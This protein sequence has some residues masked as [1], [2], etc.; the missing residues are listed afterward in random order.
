MPQPIPPS[1]GSG[2]E[3][4]ASVRPTAATG[5]ERTRSPLDPASPQDKLRRKNIR[6]CPM[7]AEDGAELEFSGEVMT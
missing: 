6:R 1:P 2:R 4:R 3:H 7:A 5:A